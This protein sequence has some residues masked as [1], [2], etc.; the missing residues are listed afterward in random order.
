MNQILFIMSMGLIVSSLAVSQV[1]EAFAQIFIPC[2]EDSECAFLTN[3]CA[4]WACDGLCAPQG[5]LG[6]SPEGT[7][8]EQEDQCTTGGTCSGPGTATGHLGI[9]EDNDPIDCDDGEFCTI[10]SCDSA[11]G[12]F[13]TPNTAPECQLVAGSLTPIDTTMVL[14]AG[15]Q[16]I[17]AWMIP[18]IVSAA[19]I[20]IVIARK[21]SKYQPI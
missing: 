6:I 7:S 4:V 20:A 2:T 1:N 8:C 5:Q 16:S 14:A 19:G 21:F 13:T 15:V 10:D 12:C 18:I 17:S 11:T 9:C 3:E